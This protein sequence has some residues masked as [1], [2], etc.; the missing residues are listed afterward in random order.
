MGVKHTYVGAISNNEIN[1]HIAKNSCDDLHHVIII[2]GLTICQ[3]MEIKIMA[4]SIASLNFSNEI[5]NPAIR[6]VDHQ[7]NQEDY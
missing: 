6:S 5:H 7:R 1:P 2:I 3:L 4:N